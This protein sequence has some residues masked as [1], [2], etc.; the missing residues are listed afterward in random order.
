MDWMKPENCLGATATEPVK[1]NIR[2]FAPK[3]NKANYSCDSIPIQGEAGATIEG[4]NSQQSFN[5]TTWKGT[6]Y[7][8]DIRFSFKI[9]GNSEASKMSA[10]DQ[11]EYQEYLKLKEKFG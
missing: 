3:T 1:S 6:D 10:A 4:S 5:T 7:S 9:K 2:L 8:E 11:A